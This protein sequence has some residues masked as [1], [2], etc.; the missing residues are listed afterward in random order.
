MYFGSTGGGNC[1]APDIGSIGQF[2]VRVLVCDDTEGPTRPD[3]CLQ[4]NP[5]SGKYKPVGQAQINA[6]KM[7]FAAFGYLMD[8]DYPGSVTPLSPAY[9]APCN[10]SGWNRCRYGGV[11][12][13]PMK[14][15]G[16]TKY[17]ANQTASTNLANEV[18]A[19]GTLTTDPEGNAASAAGSYSGFINY[20][21]K[22]GASGVYKRYDTMG[23]MYYEA[24]RYFQN[25][26]PT[27]EAT[28]GTITNS[29]KDF[30]PI[31]TTWTDPLLSS[32]SS[33]YIINLSDANT[34]DDTYLPGYNGSPAAGYG[35]AG[36]RPV[37]GGLD[38]VLWTQRIGQ[39]ESS[40]SS[41]TTDDVRPGLSGLESRSTGAG[42][43]SYLVAGAAFWANVSD[44]RSDLPGKQTIKTISFDVA[45]GSINVHDRQLYLMGKYGGF[46]NT[47][48][49][50]SD[51]FANPFYSIDP[52]NPAAP[53][54]RSNSEWEDA[55]GSGYPANYLLA[56]DPQKLINGL[57]A[58]FARIGAQSGNL[59]GAALTSANL[60]Y[61]AAGAYVA[62]FN[63]S[64][65]SGSVLYNSLSVDAMGNLVVSN[66]PI[67]DS[68]AILSAR[69]GTVTSGA[70][71]CTDT[72]VSVNKRNIVTTVQA[73]RTLL[74]AGTRVAKPF[75]LTDITASADTLYLLALNTSPQTGLPDLHWGSR[76]STTC[77]AIVLT[78]SRRSA[79]ARA[80]PRWATS[81]TR[82]R[83]IPARRR[84]R[85]PTATTR[86][87]SRPTR[88][89]RVPS[90]SVRTTACCTPSARRTASSCSPTCPDSSIR[91]STT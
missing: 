33:N 75:T 81:S 60:T 10:D 9:A 27:P 65:W 69:C 15:L 67:W 42:T 91:T 68:G 13:A 25:L 56:S 73:G 50:A 71:T 62:T 74:T 30:F 29:V 23:E 36:S 40:T 63:P 77:A 19:D 35:R 52:A 18:N 58:A 8:H 14:Y 39:L 44:I 46:N 26:G 84:P 5:P 21:N 72:D 37:T 83:S 20:I 87:S 70:T 66:T 32:C 78:N 12:R 28:S 17:D 54:S 88:I 85:S 31:T 22:F 11:L 38:T 76:A 7:R 86:P 82:V 61:G 57:R 47:I 16:P 55:V 6:A 89:A 59:S 49:R 80:I 34:W 53:A 4:Y 64:K 1:S 51:T 41:I 3:L 43:A 24:I 90:T 45:E 48:D 2:Q 79:S